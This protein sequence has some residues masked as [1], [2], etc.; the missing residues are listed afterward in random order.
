MIENAGIDAHPSGNPLFV[1]I[2]VAE[3][4]GALLAGMAV[5]ACAAQPPALGT[6]TAR[7]TINGQ[8]TG[9]AHKVAC[10]Q[11]GWDWRIETL[12][13]RPGFTALFQTGDTLIAE[14]VQIRDLGGFTGSYWRYTVGEADASVVNR[15]FTL[16]GTAVGY[17]SQE[18]DELGSSATFTIKTDC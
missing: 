1:A 12:D 5:A 4:A 7:V 8:D 13:E 9:R 11:F 14:S 16:I 2:A 17:T 6:H 10:S 18:P 3:M 15:T